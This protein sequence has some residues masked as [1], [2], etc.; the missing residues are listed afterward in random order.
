MS[1]DTRNILPCL[2]LE[3]ALRHNRVFSD[4]VYAVGNGEACLLTLCVGGN[5]LF[6]D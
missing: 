3:N 5:L 4:R 6:P 1:F 2:V